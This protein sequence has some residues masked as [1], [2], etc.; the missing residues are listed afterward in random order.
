MA[1][2]ACWMIPNIF[3]IA[4]ALLV[5]IAAQKKKSEFLYINGLYLL[6]GNFIGIFGSILTSNITGWSIFFQLLV[7]IFGLCLLVVADKMERLEGNRR[8]Y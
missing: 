8:L 3:F 6:L 7:G 1:I 2:E 4:S 5:F